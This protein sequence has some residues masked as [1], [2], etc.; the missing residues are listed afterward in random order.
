M[1]NLHL[2]KPVFQRFLNSLS[3][4]ND[5]AILD[6]SETSIRGIVTNEDN[7]FILWANIDGE[8][9]SEFTLNLPS[10]R[11]LEKSLDLIVSEDFK[12][13]VNSNRLEYSGD[14]VKFKYHLFDNGVITRPKISLEKI[15]SLNYDIEFDLSRSF[16]LNLLKQSSVFKTTNKLYIHTEDGHLVFS[17]ADKS[18]ANS[19]E[20]TIIGDPVD[21]ELNK[22]I[23]NLDNIRLLTLDQDLIKFRINSSSCIG[24]FQLHSKGMVLNYITTTLRE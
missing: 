16:V 23:I 22:F 17:L 3:K 6:I 9:D 21:F 24:N 18:M 8:F 4:L 20:L 5:S 11:K 14:N 12:F 19:D 13:K 10:L 1:S 7:T 2:Q 15:Q